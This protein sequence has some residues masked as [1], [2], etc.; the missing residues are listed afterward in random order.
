MLKGVLEK[1]VYN[2]GQTICSSVKLIKI[3]KKNTDKIA[4]YSNVIICC[5]PKHGFQLVEL[6][7]LYHTSFYIAN[8]TGVKRET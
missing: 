2:L 4:V 3:E 8:T 5:Q 7:L 1:K 6:K